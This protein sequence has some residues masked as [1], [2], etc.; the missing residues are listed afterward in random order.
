[1]TNNGSFSY[2]NKNAYHINSYKLSLK[3]LICSFITADDLE[4]EKY[5]NIFAECLNFTQILKNKK[6]SFNLEG[7][8]S[9]YDNKRINLHVSVL[10]CKKTV[11]PN[12]I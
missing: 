7:M 3:Y 2:K 4:G 12:F 11:R 6:D 1:M 9:I 10:H 8:K 5:N